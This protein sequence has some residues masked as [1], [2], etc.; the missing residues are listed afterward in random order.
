MGEPVSGKLVVAA[1]FLRYHPRL[2]RYALSIIRMRDTA[3]S[4]TEEE[5]RPAGLLRSSAFRH[6]ISDLRLRETN[7][8]WVIL[9]GQYA[10]KIKKRVTL[11][12]VDQSTLDRRKALCEEELRLNRRLASDL[13]EGVVP[14]TRDADGPAVAGRGPTVEY[15]VKMKQFEASQEL[16]ALLAPGRCRCFG[17]PGLA[18]R[19]ADFHQS[20]QQAPRAAEFASRAAVHDAVL[21]NLP[22]SC[23]ILILRRSCLIGALVDWIHD[24]LHDY[25]PLLGIREQA[26]H[27]RECHGDLHAGNIV[28]WGGELV[29][30]DSL[31]FDPALRWIDVMSDVAFLFMDLISHRR[32]DLAF[33]F[34]NAY[35]A[36]G[37]DY[38]GVRLL[39]FYSIYRALVRAMVDELAAEDQSELRGE[40]L[41]RCRGRLKTALALLPAQAPCLIIMHG[42]SG[43]GKSTI[44]ARL[45][46]EL[47]AV[48]I[49]SDVERKRLQRRTGAHQIHR[50]NSTSSP[51]RI[52]IHVRRPPSGRVSVIVDAAFLEAHHRDLFR[53]W[54]Q[55]HGTPF[56][57]VCCR[58]D[59]PV[60][61]ARIADRQKLGVDPSDADLGVLRRQI[62]SFDPLSDAETH[63]LVEV[64][65][66]STNSNRDARQ[67]RIFVQ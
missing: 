1:H 7:L 5:F 45:A 58:A 55:R 37:G 18:T 29:P 46:E 2:H 6:P 42:L 14:I 60:L 24:F 22:R 64:D 32:R 57:I 11:S 49:R 26:G 43:S 16:S 4:E 61:K 30:F 54:A 9:T 8:A 63:S 53:T 13:Y 50:R 36:R 33:D 19:L 51:I 21:G 41:A 3:M 48:L 65:T 28:R 44:G 31:E 12:F 27:V 23:V 56:L 15:A 20:G 39:R 67:C 66:M 25:Q 38:D 34:L 59:V 17:T 62:E 35:L 52:Y 47:G 40:Y 10:Y